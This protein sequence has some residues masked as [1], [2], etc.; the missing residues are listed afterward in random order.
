MAFFVQQSFKVLKTKNISDYPTQNTFGIGYNNVMKICV[1]N[2]N[3]QEYLKKAS[4]IG[5]KTLLHQ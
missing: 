1:L 5:L 2:F 3:F 4:L